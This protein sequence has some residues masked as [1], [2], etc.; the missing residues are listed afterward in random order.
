MLKNVNV[1]LLALGAVAL[2]VIAALIF[3]GIS[4]FASEGLLDYLV[5]ESNRAS[6]YRSITKLDYGTLKEARGNLAVFTDTQTYYPSSTVVTTVYNIDTNQKVYSH[7]Q[8]PE[9]LR[10]TT[11]I[12]GSVSDQAYFYTKTVNEE[13][14]IVSAS[15]YN[16]N[17][18][19]LA[20]TDQNPNYA[21]YNDEIVAFDGI[22]YEVN[23]SGSFGRSFEI[24][25]FCS[26]ERTA[27]ADV[28]GRDYLYF[29]D[30]DLLLVTDRKGNPIA[31]CPV[32]PYDSTAEHFSWGVL[33]NGNI[34][35]Q[36]ILMVNDNEDDFDF[37]YVQSGKNTKYEVITQILK[38]K[39]NSVKE[40]DIDYIFDN[41]LFNHNTSD[42]EGFV[43]DFDLNYT[44]VI[45]FEDGILHVSGKNEYV[46]IDNDL[47]IEERTSD[48]VDGGRYV[49]KLTEYLFAVVDHYGY[50][51]F[52]NARGKVLKTVESSAVDF[53]AGYIV[54]RNAIYDTEFK[55]VYDMQ[56]NGYTLSSSAKTF[57]IL[58]KEVNGETVYAKFENGMVNTIYCESG[59]TVGTN[60][61][62]D[63]YYIENGTK[64]SF[65]D[66]SGSLI[67][68]VDG[69]HAYLSNKT[70]SGAYLINASTGYYRLNP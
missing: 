70:D 18:T 25:D 41:D 9:S 26:I 42:P 11:V 60:Y 15:L 43:E 12:L 63:L 40:V 39:S 10:T 32:R 27:G 53:A 22:A 48:L 23:E 50:V 56:A 57:L 55:V 8:T 69:S 13:G 30:N 24:D 54:G 44:R 65:Y 59:A 61:S 38:V 17:G 67:G 5:T 1:K 52:I 49:S 45:F 14:K 2:I 35:M 34:A 21:E 29:E 16:E 19:V 3:V 6:D 51:H 66:A 36:Y 68:S 7:T 31:S 20:T 64:V 37:S 46:V 4:I 62:A 47:D 28:V 58:K 33:E